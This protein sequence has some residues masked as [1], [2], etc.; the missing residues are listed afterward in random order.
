LVDRRYTKF[1]GDVVAERACVDGRIC[2]L[3]NDIVDED[4]KGLASW[5]HKHIAYAELHAE[6]R[7]TP[8][9]PHQ[10][11]RKII[12][13]NKS[14]TRPLFLFVL[15]DLI[16]PAAPAK[17]L[18]LFIF[19]Y[20]IRLGFLDGKSGLRFCIYHGWHEMNIAGFRAEVSQLP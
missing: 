17:P 1:N 19:M 7:G 18:V 6:R 10:R 12:D 15:R 5:L 3:R 2:R 13:R 20:I 9:S 14:D 4:L 16:F 11:L 8:L